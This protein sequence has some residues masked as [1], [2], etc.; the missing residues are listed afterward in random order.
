M[1]SPQA[2]ISF[3]DALRMREYQRHCWG[4]MNSV[5]LFDGI[6]IEDDF[7]IDG[8]KFGQ[9]FAW[10]NGSVSQN[11]TLFSTDYFPFR[12]TGA[13]ITNWFNGKYCICIIFEQRTGVGSDFVATDIIAHT[14]MKS[15]KCWNECTKETIMEAMRYCNSMM[16]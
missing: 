10:W 3:E 16:A 4:D 14:S 11:S 2:F 8:H 6:G 15:L 13:I 9:E 7:T 12:D 5:F 1:S